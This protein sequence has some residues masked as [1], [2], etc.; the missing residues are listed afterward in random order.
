MQQ[1]LYLSVLAFCRLVPHDAIVADP[2]LL[3]KS[4]GPKAG[5]YR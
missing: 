5:A 4:A 2:V 1:G 3:V